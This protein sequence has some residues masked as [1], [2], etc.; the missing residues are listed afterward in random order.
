MIKADF[1]IHSDFSADAEASME[2]TI[3]QAISVGLDYICFTDHMDY[4]YPSEYH[5]D[6][7][8]SVEEYFQQISRLQKQYEHKIKILAGIELGVKPELNSK[9]K[10]LLSIYSFDFVIASS[11]LIENYDPYY[12]DFWEKYDT[13]AGIERYFQSIIENVNSFSDFDVYGH[14]DYIIRYAPK[15]EMHFSYQKYANLLDNVLNT[16]IQTGKGIEVNTAGYKYGLGH[17]HP[18]EDI[19]KRYFELGGTYI[20]I[21]SDSHK[22][23]QVAYD[24]SKTKEMLL[25]LGITQYAI[26]EKRKPIFLSLL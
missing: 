16:I 8:F 2:K 24:F 20:T 1:H 22:P 15:N 6:F 3:Q 19:L 7:T 26:F 21:G 4:D 18:Q 14:L 25:S 11:H 23:E 10:Q 5:M 17:P 9:L 12:P 13:N